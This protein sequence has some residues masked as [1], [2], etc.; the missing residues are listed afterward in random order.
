MGLKRLSSP[1]LIPIW[2]AALALGIIIITL[3]IRRNYDAPELP[4]PKVTPGADWASPQDAP[5][6][7]TISELKDGTGMSGGS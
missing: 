1:G 6:K 5:V 3:E 2:L 4:S 7:D